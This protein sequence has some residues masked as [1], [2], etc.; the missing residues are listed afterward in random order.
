MYQPPYSSP[1]P[2]DTLV[3]QVPRQI[4]P[5]TYVADSGDLV[6]DGRPMRVGVSYA[7][8]GGGQPTQAQLAKVVL[9]ILSK[10]PHILQAVA[11]WMGA[12]IKPAPARG[13]GRAAWQ[14]EMELRRLLAMLPDDMAD[15]ITLYVADL[16]PLAL[17]RLG[18]QTYLALEIAD[19]LYQLGDSEVMREAMAAR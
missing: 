7:D 4:D 13:R 3:P 1:Q 5:G 19:L 17:S 16:D 6:V 11:R 8:G 15:A 10:Y 18:E 14:V 9:L 12:I 2:P